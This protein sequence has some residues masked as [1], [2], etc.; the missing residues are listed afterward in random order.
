MMGTSYGANSSNFVFSEQNVRVAAMDFKTA[1]NNQDMILEKYIE[2]LNTIQTTSIKSG[3]AHEAI[4]KLTELIKPG[5]E[6][7]KTKGDQL[8]SNLKEFIAAIDRIDLEL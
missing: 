8:D 4:K 1:L 3:E 5:Y 2:L 7:C 6:T